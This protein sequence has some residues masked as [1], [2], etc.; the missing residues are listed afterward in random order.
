[1]PK[2]IDH[3]YNQMKLLPVSFDRQILPGTFEHTL[4]HLID[5]ELDLSIF[6]HRF[7]NDDG[8]RPAFSPAILLKIVLLAYSR[9]ITS[10]RKIEA[11][12]RENVLFMAISADSHPHFTTIAEFISSS[13]EEIA[14]LFQQ[15]LLICGQMGLIE[16]QMFAIDGCKMPSNASKEWSGS[17]ADLQRKADKID[18][19]VR[20]MMRKHRD[21]DHSAG[22]DIEIRKRE[23]QQLE[24]LRKTSDK[25]KRFL[26]DNDDRKGRYT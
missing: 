9:G 25:I 2:F 17:K 16:K 8:G 3:D 14:K 18:R 1:M 6:D 19:A 13:Y 15:V 11:L 22:N 20:Y 10:S 5:N 23:E 24:K 12:C 21:E 26:A 7:N 4:H